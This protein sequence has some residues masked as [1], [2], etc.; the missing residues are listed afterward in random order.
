MDA[1]IPHRAQRYTFRKQ[2]SQLGNVDDTHNRNIRPE[3]SRDAPLHSVD[4]TKNTKTHGYFDEPK[5]DDVFGLR[6]YAPFHCCVSSSGTEALN[7]LSKTSVYPLR[8]EKGVWQ[9]DNLLR[10]VSISLNAES[11]RVRTHTAP[12]MKM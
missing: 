10:L 3:E 8:D 6:R 4:N 7:V 9:A 5:T 12:I 2:H 11:R 1:R